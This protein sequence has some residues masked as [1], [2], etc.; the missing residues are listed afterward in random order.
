MAAIFNKGVVTLL[1]GVE[2]DTRTEELHTLTGRVSLFARED[3]ALVSDHIVL[4]P[5][6]L[7][8]ICHVGNVPGD[9]DQGR[10]ERAKTAFDAL[11]KL[12]ATRGVFEVMTEHKLY[13]DM[14]FLGVELTHSA[15]FSGAITIRARFEEAPLNTVETLV[16]PP[17]QLE[18]AGGGRTDKTASDE[19]NAGR[20]NTET[21]ETADT[22]SVAAQIL[23]RQEAKYAASN[24]P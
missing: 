15:A 6:V 3:R 4:D 11:Q 18:Q 22:R 12:R 2:V 23:D 21:E 8:I 1:E 9:P 5:A 20:Q 14:A 24:T 17:A 10:A 13:T 7:E 16:L 19:V